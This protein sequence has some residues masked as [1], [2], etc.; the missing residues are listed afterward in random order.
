MTI[1]IRKEKVLLFTYSQEKYI[2]SN[3]NAPAAT[4]AWAHIMQYVPL[5]IVY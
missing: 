4:G 3:K 5:T 2:N 1:D